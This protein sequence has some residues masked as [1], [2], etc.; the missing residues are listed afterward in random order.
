M[1]VR[2]PACV[3]VLH[4]QVC[5]E[6]DCVGAFMPPHFDS[7]GPAPSRRSAGV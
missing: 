4:L 7:A 6:C 5:G 1:C 2:V 3:R